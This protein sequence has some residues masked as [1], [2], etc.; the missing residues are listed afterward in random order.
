MVYTTVLSMRSLECATVAGSAIPRSRLALCK[1]EQNAGCFFM[2]VGTAVMGISCSTDQSI[3]MTAATRCGTDSDDSGQRGERWYRA[4][5]FTGVGN[6]RVT[7][8]RPDRYLTA[9]DSNAR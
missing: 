3:V 1:T 7:G 6:I 4:L 8:H 9:T 5:Y 2:T